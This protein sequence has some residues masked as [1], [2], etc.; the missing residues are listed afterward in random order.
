[1]Q[2]YYRQFVQVTPLSLPGIILVDTAVLVERYSAL[3]VW[4]N[5]V[6][7]CRVRAIIYQGGLCS[8]AE[9]V[10]LDGDNPD[11][12]L[13]VYEKAQD[14]AR[15]Y[16]IEG[17]TYRLTQGGTVHYI[18]SSSYSLLLILLPTIRSC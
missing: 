18:C 10:S 4:C 11:H 5:S 1:M 2:C 8:L 12:I 16:R 9:G 15:E 7:W 3:S 14:R 6:V 13:W 17:V